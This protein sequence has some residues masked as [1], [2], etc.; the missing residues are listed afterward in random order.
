[1]CSSDLVDRDVAA[2]QI[3]GAARRA[4]QTMITDVAVF[5][6]F[7]GEALGAD[8]K[9]VAIEVTLQPTERTLT[10]EEIEAFGTKIVE[11]VAKAT[12]GELRG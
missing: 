10:D 5:D 7:E 12:G 2:D 6:L 4:D 11:A 3:V 1:V 9:S 8:K